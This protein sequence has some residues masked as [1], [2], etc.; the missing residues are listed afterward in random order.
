MKYSNSFHSS[1]IFSL[2]H[3]YSTKFNASANP[4]KRH[5]KFLTS[6]TF[7]LCKGEL[8]RISSTFQEVKV[9]SGVAW[10]TVAGKD[11]ILQPGENASIASNKDIALVS[12]LG[13]VSL[14][15][16]VC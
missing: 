4:I 6:C 2:V 10:I 12:A 1:R 11:I 16:T 15:L 3:R 13:D 5:T 7:T 8:F 9:L 14:V